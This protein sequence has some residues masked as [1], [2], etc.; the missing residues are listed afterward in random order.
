VAVDQLVDEQDEGDSGSRAQ[1]SED[2]RSR[3]TPSRTSQNARRE[4][5]MA[6]LFC[7]EHI[8]RLQRSVA[9]SLRLL[10][11]AASYPA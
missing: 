4:S 5:P 2:P 8:R 1:S 3:I 9:L 11:I 7:V 10:R 6:P